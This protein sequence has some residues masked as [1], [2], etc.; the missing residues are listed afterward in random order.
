MN[1][2]KVNDFLTLKLERGKTNFYVKDELFKQCH[3]L[4]LIVRTKETE[5]FNDIESIDEIADRLGWTGYGQEGVKYE[6]AR[7]IKGSLNK[8]NN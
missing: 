5:N 1:E 6:I 2:F 3:F 4:K 8:K 7:A